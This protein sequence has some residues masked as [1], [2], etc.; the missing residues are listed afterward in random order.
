M[1]IYKS[2]LL[3]LM[4]LLLITNVFATSNSNVFSDHIYHST[5]LINNDVEVIIEVVDI[6]KNCDNKYHYHYGVNFNIKSHSLSNQVYNITFNLYFFAELGTGE[7]IYGGQYT[8]TNEEP[9]LYNIVAHNN[10]KGV[11][12]KLLEEYPCE[13]LSL[14]DIGLKSVRMDYWGGYNGSKIGDFDSTP[15]PIELVSFTAESQNNNVELA[16]ETASELNNDF[17]TLYRSNDGV[18]YSEIQHIKGSGNTSHLIS[19]KFTDEN[20]AQGI[21][22]YKLKQTDFD[23]RSI[24]YGPISVVVMDDQMEIS[25]FPNPSLDNKL[26]IKSEQL[27]S[28]KLLVY[29]SLGE[30]VHEVYIDE[31]SR[32]AF[33]LNEG[34]GVY[35][36]H[37]HDKSGKII[38]KKIVLY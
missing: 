18:S 11:N 36:L 20:L 2:T 6:V 22:Y 28:G 34:K 26:E 8:I 12:G 1:R 3:L 32:V 21:Y 16:W 38:S 14:S 25:V 9:H 37:F 27:L 5:I 19:Y 17:F 24:T 13:S 31:K 23:G 30:L 15:L 35:T 4:N 33:T 29:N 7:H 10:G